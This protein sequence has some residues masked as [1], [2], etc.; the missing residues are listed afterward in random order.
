[1]G[2]TLQTPRDIHMGH[3]DGVLRSVTTHNP[4]DDNTEASPLIHNAA[5]ASSL[6]QLTESQSHKLRLLS[7]LS[8]ASAGSSLTYPS[9]I[10]ALGLSTP[11]ELETL[12]TSAIYAD[13]ISASL[14]PAKQI[15]IISSVA[16]L[17]DLRPGSVAEMVGELEEW[18]GRCEVVLLEIEEEIERVKREAGR[19]S[20]REREV[21]VQKERA[22]VKWAESGGEGGESLLGG[23][24]GRKMKGL[25]GDGMDLDFDGGRG[26]G[27]RI[28]EGGQKKKSVSW[29]GMKK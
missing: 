20:G 1:M 21:G 16:P 12:V 11:K 23:G 2:R 27:G 29:F 28:G 13:L 3:M 26:G 17:R 14:N 5:N 9:L 24:G 19:R 7:L 15:V 22:A 4:S 25:G 8:L 18:K 6:P 10:S